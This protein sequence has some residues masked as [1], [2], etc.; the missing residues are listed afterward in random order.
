MPPPS[1]YDAPAPWDPSVTVERWVLERFA[2]AV[3][4]TPS[5]SALAVELAALG[6][7]VPSPERPAAGDVRARAFADLDAAHA[8][9]LGLSRGE[10][11]VVL[12][13]FTELR[14]A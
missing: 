12:A 13:T 11:E 5:L 10:L 1:A 8:V 6:V 2:L 7:A 14:R 4:W 3:A 9:L